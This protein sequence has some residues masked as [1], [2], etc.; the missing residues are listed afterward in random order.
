MDLIQEGQKYNNLLVILVAYYFVFLADLVQLILFIGQAKTECSKY[1][2]SR[3]LC[4]DKMLILQVC[5]YSVSNYIYL[6]FNPQYLH[7]VLPNSCY[8]NY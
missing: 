2:Q 8:C 7:N 4:T 3:C 5:Q 1:P 6:S